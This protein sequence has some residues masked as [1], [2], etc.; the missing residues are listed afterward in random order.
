[1]D[2]LDSD[3]F[4]ILI[5]RP[6]RS[7]HG[8]HPAF[9]DR[10]DNFVGTD[11]VADPRIDVE[12]RNRAIR[13]ARCVEQ[14]RSRALLRG[15]QRLDL[16]TKRRISR[17]RRGQVRVASR[18]VQLEDVPE[19]FLDLLPAFGGHDVKKPRASSRG[20]LRW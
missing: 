19:Y 11:A 15:Q 4:L 6:H 13:L 5:V 16:S 8:A 18:T 17:T 14:V 2:K 3:L 9:A 10:F 1:M 7:V 12:A 20:R